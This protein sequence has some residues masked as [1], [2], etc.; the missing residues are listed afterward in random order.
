MSRRAARNTGSRD[1]AA[2]GDGRRFPSDGFALGYRPALDGVRC[3]A[4]VGV[5]AQHGRVP[6]FQGA[7]KIGVTLFF[8]LSGFLITRLLVEEANTT[9]RIDLRGF[10]TRRALRLFPALAAVVV[11]SIAGSVATGKGLGGAQYTLLYVANIA[12]A[13]GRAM[14]FLAHTWSLSLEEQF[15]VFWPVTLL[16]C[17][18]V[19]R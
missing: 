2:A 1:Q 16:V 9:G 14:P 11:I 7:G 13:A 12:R 15:Y 10:Y 19:A 8:V 5:L 3:L 6:V 4:I 18:V 17:L